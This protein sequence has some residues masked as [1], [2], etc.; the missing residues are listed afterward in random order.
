[1]VRQYEIHTDIITVIIPQEDNMSFLENLRMQ[2]LYPT[3]SGIGP[4]QVGPGGLGPQPSD[5][6]AP[7]Y[8]QRGDPFEE[9]ISRYLSLMPPPQPQ[10]RREDRIQQ[11]GQD[12]AQPE[13]QRPINTVYKPSISD[14]QRQTLGL[15]ERALEGIEE[16]REQ[17]L[18][19]QQERTDIQRQRT[20]IQSQ[21]AAI[22]DWKAK[23]PNMRIMAIKGGNLIAINPQTGESHD[24]GIS[25][26][27]LSD[28]DRLELTQENTLGRITK[29]GEVTSRQIEERGEQQRT[30][31]RVPTTQVEREELPT[32]T[33]VRQFNKARE[34]INTHPEWAPFIKMG[35]N[36]FSIEAPDPGSE[37]F[38]INIGAGGPSK[39][40]YDAINK[41]IYTSE[42][43]KSVKPSI[44]SKPGLTKSTAPVAPKGWKY[45][46]KPGGG[47][48]AVES[49]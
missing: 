37:Y 10:R 13:I 6:F 2:T 4:Y 8:P 42:S 16:G 29:Q 22:Y 46:P 15:R 27:S 28:E 1:L 19:I 5:S 48:T 21:R 35:T 26:G 11:I 45:I 18:G 30:T 41:F 40:I 24:L 20:G 32:Q 7:Q 3:S 44:L 43:K 33:K 36:D 34:A 23:N 25:S 47:W 12:I 17:N 31:K 49:K 9:V 14:Y 39:D 38:G